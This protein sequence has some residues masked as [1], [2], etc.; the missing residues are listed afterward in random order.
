MCCQDKW[1]WAVNQVWCHLSETVHVNLVGAIFCESCFATSG[2]DDGR[3][4]CKSASFGRIAEAL[5]CPPRP[6]RPRG[7]PT[8]R[9]G[10][11][12]LSLEAEFPDCTSYCDPMLEV[13]LAELVMRRWPSLRLKWLSYDGEFAHRIPNLDGQIAHSNSSKLLQTRSDSSYHRR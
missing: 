10:D 3:C 5:T 2:L 1:I 9:N 6:P 12:T 13:K 7:P 4:S 11:P 8:M